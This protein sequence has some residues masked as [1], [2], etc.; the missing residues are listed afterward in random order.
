VA[1]QEARPL[2]RRPGLLANQNWNKM[3]GQPAAAAAAGGSGLILGDRQ[4][5]GA[6]WD[7]LCAGARSGGA[8]AMG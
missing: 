2:A 5:Q 4:A 1:G 6:C 7:K 8:V 3:V